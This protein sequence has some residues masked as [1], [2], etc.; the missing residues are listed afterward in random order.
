VKFPTVIVTGCSRGIGLQVALDLIREGYYILS[1]GRSHPKLP[2]ELAGNLSHLECDLSQARESKEVSHWIQANQSQHDFLGFIHIAG[3]GYTVPLLDATAES[4][5]EQL[6]VNLVSAILLTRTI[7]PFLNR[8]RSRIFFIGSRARRFSFLGGSAYCASKAGLYA[9]SDCLAL[10]VRDLGWNIGVTILEFGPV[11]TGF[12][13]LEISNKQISS[14]GAASI[15]V[16][17]FVAPLADY[18]VRAVEVV[19]SVERLRND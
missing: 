6:N 10:E 16:R 8:H 13:G 5:I 7:L 1:I 4:M 15:I 3:V 2:L 17:A 19:P 9:L 11:A 12:A 18:D 14:A